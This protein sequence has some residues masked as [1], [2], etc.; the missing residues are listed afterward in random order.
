MTKMM[1][2][3]SFTFPVIFRKC[4]QLFVLTGSHWA[5]MYPPRQCMT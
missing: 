5:T 2:S 3:G 4:F 1:Q